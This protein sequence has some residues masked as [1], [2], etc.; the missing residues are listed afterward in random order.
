MSY[1]D[2]LG[3]MM[4]PPLAPPGAQ[5]GFWHPPVTALPGGTSGGYQMRN[6]CENMGGRYE[7]HCRH[8][9]PT[10]MPQPGLPPGI[11]LPNAGKLCQRYCHLPSGE[12]SA[13]LEPEGRWS[14]NL[15]AISGYGFGDSTVAGS[16]GLG[17][18]LGVGVGIGLLIWLAG[19]ASSTKGR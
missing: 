11:Q 5:P 10:M 12:S 8:M 17:I 18:L 9:G 13:F 16:T 7:E 14:P 3:I 15:Q 2:G 19:A 4:T 6:Q 1:Y